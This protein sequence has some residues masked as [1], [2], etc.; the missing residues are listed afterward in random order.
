MVMSVESAASA[1]GVF[2]APALDRAWARNPEFVS[3]RIG[4]EVLLLPITQNMGD[5]E[6][7]F[8]LNEVGAR[9]WELL[10]GRHTVADIRDQLVSEFEVSASTA[11]AHLLEFLMSLDAL[12]A[13]RPA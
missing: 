6:S 5:L 7:I 2:R 9:V 8:T 4:R 11:E 3:R 1:K 12:G 13:L 10:D